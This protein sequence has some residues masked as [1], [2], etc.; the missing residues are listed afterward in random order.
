MVHCFDIRA[1]Q[2]YGVSEAI[3]LRALAFRIQK[4]KARGRHQH[5]VEIEGKKVMRTWTYNSAAAWSK[6]FPY[7]TSWQVERILNSLKK[8]GVIVTGHFSKAPTD[9]SLSYALVNEERWINLDSVKPPNQ[10]HG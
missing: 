1:A 4:N 5:E 2:H 9:R 3:I 8:Q 10:S 7:W 6:V